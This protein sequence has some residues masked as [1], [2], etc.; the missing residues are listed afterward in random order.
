LSRA[1]AGCR[2]P[3]L[4]DR[5]GVL[6]P[7]AG[8]SADALNWRSGLEWW[9]PGEIGFAWLDSGLRICQEELERWRPVFADGAVI[10][11]HDTGPQH[12]VGGFL[13][14]LH[15]QGWLQMLTLQTPRGVSFLQIRG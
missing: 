7:W 10:G 9:P 4:T 12:P 1:A 3:C 14:R 15:E 2:V 5:L 13:Q 11:V 6:S 8:Q